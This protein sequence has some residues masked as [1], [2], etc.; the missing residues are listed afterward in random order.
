MPHPSPKNVVFNRHGDRPRYSPHAS[1]KQ[2]IRLIFA[3]GC[4]LAL[5][6]MLTYGNRRYDNAIQ[7]PN[8]T[9]SNGPVAA[10]SKAIQKDDYP[11]L[12]ESDHVEAP[13]KTTTAEEAT[14]QAVRN[15]TDP[16]M[17]ISKPIQVSHATGMNRYP[18]EYLAVKEFLRKRSST[19]KTIKLLSFGSSYGNEAISLAT[20]YFNDEEGF[21]D[22]TIHGF[23]IDDE[24]IRVS[25]EH[26]ARHEKHLPVHFFDGRETP[27]NFD[28]KYDAIFANS[29][30]CDA[31][32]DP[33]SVEVVEAH[34]PFRDF[35]ASLLKL[36]AA[37]N[38]GGAHAI[39]NSSYNFA[40]S[41]LADR[42]EV[43]SQCS[44]DFVPK[45]DLEKHEFV[46]NSENAKRDCVWRKRR[47]A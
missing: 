31:T 45:I 26:V 19:G 36:D 10:F 41:T 23:D 30:L 18:D 44:G 27:L 1:Y 15:F 28:G 20:L 11:A 33:M 3:C 46:F 22:V 34:F 9:N 4:V 17:M 40:D 13:A 21:P 5:I 6:Q 29:V 2:V 32:S 42:Y 39:I 37:L 14:I 16:D 8:E 25:K 7:N 12:I 35:E 24:T 43:V 38:D 47:S